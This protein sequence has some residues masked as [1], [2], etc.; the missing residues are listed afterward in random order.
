MD[1]KQIAKQS[2]N[3][4][5]KIYPFVS[6]FVLHL[7]IWLTVAMAIETAIVYMTP[8]KLMRVCKV[9]RA[10]N[11]FLFII[12][13]VV[14]VDVHYFWTF[15]LIK[16]EKSELSEILCTTVKQGNSNSSDEFRDI[17]WPILDIL[18]SHFFPYFIIFSCTVIMITKRFRRKDQLKQMETTWKNNSVDPS[19]AKQ[20]QL[21]FIFLCLCYLVLLLPKFACDIFMFVKNTS[22][23]YEHMKLIDFSLE[24]EAKSLLADAI[25]STL[26]FVFHSF[27]FLPFV[28]VSSRFREEL[29]KLLSCHQCRGESLSPEPHRAPTHQPLLCK[30]SNSFTKTE[31]NCIARME[32]SMTSV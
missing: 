21:A 6:D 17:I 4:A 22:Q 18:I 5:C 13:L 27:K 15:A 32:F 25:C 23:N 7:S 11:V 29:G 12:V 28:C 20:M 30:N 31:P 26:L 24:L 9:E 19:S 14:C 3:S 1:V 2:S 8:E 10:R 16:V